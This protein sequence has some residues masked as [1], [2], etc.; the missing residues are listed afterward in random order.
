VNVPVFVG[1][2]SSVEKSSADTDGRVFGAEV[3]VGLEI[4]VEGLAVDRVGD[5]VKAVEEVLEL[6]QNG[7]AE[8][9]PP[10]VWPFAQHTA[11]HWNSPTEQTLEQPTLSRPKGQQ[12][13]APLSREQ[14]SPVSQHQSPS[15]HFVSLAAHVGPTE[16][17]PRKPTPTNPGGRIAACARRK[18]YWVGG[19]VKISETAV[20][21][22]SVVSISRR[23]LDTDLRK[24][25][26]VM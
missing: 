6:T 13:K 20:A 16:S 17:R 7:V 22:F 12:R 14:A 24:P 26:V 5:V 3:V 15:V 10:Q 8:S 18:R 25:I 11:P 23:L 4:V 21:L 2:S 9:P 1:A 19:T